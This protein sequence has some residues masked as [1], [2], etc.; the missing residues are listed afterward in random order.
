MRGAGFWFLL[1]KRL[2]AK[3]GKAKK[4]RQGPFIVRSLYPKGIVELQ[5]EKKHVL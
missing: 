2:H 5:N 3:D 4:N 1:Q